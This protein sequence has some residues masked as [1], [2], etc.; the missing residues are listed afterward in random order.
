MTRV[1]MRRRKPTANQARRSGSSPPQPLK[2]QQA[3]PV[4]FTDLDMAAMIGRLGASSSHQLLL[5]LEREAEAE[6]SELAEALLGYKDH[7][8]QQRALAKVEEARAMQRRL[9]GLFSRFRRFNGACD[10]WTTGGGPVAKRAGVLNANARRTWGQSRRSN[11]GTGGQKL[12][13][14]RRA[15]DAAMRDELRRPASNP[16]Q[17]KSSGSGRPTDSLYDRPD[18]YKAPPL[19]VEAGE[20][21]G[22]FIFRAPFAKLV[23][24]LFRNAQHHGVDCGLATK[25][26]KKSK[27]FKDIRLSEEGVGLFLGATQGYVLGLLQDARVCMQHGLRQTLMPRD[28]HLAVRVRGEPTVADQ[29]ASSHPKL[30]GIESY[31]RGEKTPRSDGIAALAGLRKPALRRLASLAGVERIDGRVY[32]EVRALAYCRLFHI[33]EAAALLLEC[34]RMSTCTCVIAIRGLRSSSARLSTRQ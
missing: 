29:E 11:N 4:L 1:H 18:A 20:I 32:D 14:I 25:Q 10:T 28:I 31:R 26:T 30:A 27:E 12:D 24:A 33:V 21:D 19:T 17:G 22:D 15:Y 16:A 9:V 2:Q 13:V 8:G 5:L 7:R 23:K 34:A 3:A 6:E